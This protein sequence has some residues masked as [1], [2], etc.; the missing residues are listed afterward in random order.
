M[1]TGPSFYIVGYNP[2]KK[3][4]KLNQT[5]TGTNLWVPIV[6]KVSRSL[7]VKDAVSP[8]VEIELT[9]LVMIDTDY[10]DRFKLSYDS[11]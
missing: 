1:N 11:C 7:Q 4:Q 3:G 9:L 5:R 6:C 2:S 8:W 10:I